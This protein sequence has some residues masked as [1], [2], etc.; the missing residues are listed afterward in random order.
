MSTSRK[1]GM[2]L[3]VVREHGPIAF[4][5]RAARSIIARAMSGSNPNECQLVWDWY[6]AHGRVG[7]MIDVG[8]HYGESLDRF[9]RGGWQVCAFEPNAASRD[10]LVKLYAAYKNLRIDGRAVSDQLA[11]DVPFYTSDR[12]TGIAGL[13]AFHQSHELAGTIET[14]TLAHALIELGLTSI[15]F[16]K[17][18]TEGFDLFVLRGLPKRTMPDTI[19]CE[20]EDR[21][22]VPL[23]YGYVDLGVELV[24]RGYTVL[25]S[26]WY[27]IKEYAGAHSWR[28][29]TKGVAP[30]L[31]SA[32]WGNFIAV[33]DPAMADDL[34][35]AFPQA[36]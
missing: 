21:K 30:L 23:G 22:T 2:A 14:T 33:R 28:R 31:D 19:V 34:L 8:A 26:E 25:M 24:D 5:K 12:S 36:R 29:V 15:D 10:A 27:P 20:F 13:S 1:I 17:I 3:L 18:D 6:K 4:A 35:K 11:V 16:L 32:G 7:T 9:V